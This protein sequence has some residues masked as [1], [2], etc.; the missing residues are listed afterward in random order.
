M[1]LLFDQRTFETIQLLEDDEHPAV[2]AENF[3]WLLKQLHEFE[4]SHM[5]ADKHWNQ[6]GRGE[7]RAER[8]NSA[9]NLGYNYFENHPFNSYT[10]TINPKGITTINSFGYPFNVE[11]F[12]VDAD[13]PVKDTA[14]K[15]TYYG[16]G[17]R[18]H[19][20]NGP[21]VCM[22]TARYDLI[23][24]KKTRC[25]V[26]CNCKDFKHSFL[27]TLQG[28][29]YTDPNAVVPPKGKNKRKNSDGSNYTVPQHAGVCKHLYAILKKYYSDIIAKV[30][31]SPDQ[32][33]EMFTEPEEAEVPSIYVPPVRPTPKGG[34]VTPP[35]PVAKPPVVPKVPAKLSTKPL[36]KTQL[37]QQASDAIRDALLAADKVIPSDQLVS[38]L[39]PRKFS[40]S[41]HAAINYHKYKFAVRVE[42]TDGKAA[43]YYMNPNQANA[44]SGQKLLTIPKLSKKDSYYLLSPKELHDLVKT[45]TTPFSSNL[46]KQLARERQ[47]L[48]P[49]GKKQIVMFYESVIQFSEELEILNEASLI[50]RSL[51]EF[52]FRNNHVSRT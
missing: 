43:I 45:Y 3:S 21:Y 51:L 2:L 52:N 36:T 26:S 11:R 20:G 13:F 37:K 38:Y 29:K 10:P 47:K 7:R 49:D 16:P 46:E 19:P 32:N 18:K 14:K 50:K 40:K 8:G 39:D 31:D 22:L 30:E 48:G 33:P 6:P 28:A 9:P 34:P 27:Y 4:P 12:E 35:K 5:L 25:Y 24:K 41:K 17:G 44:Q 23:N 15:E 42:T 1:A